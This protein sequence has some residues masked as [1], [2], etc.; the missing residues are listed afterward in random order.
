MPA[1]RLIFQTSQQNQ[2][3]ILKTLWIFA[4]YVDSMENINLKGI[5][6]LPSLGENNKKQMQDSKL[7]HEE[8]ISVF[9]MQNTCRWEQLMILRPR[10]YL[11]LI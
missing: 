2:E 4:K 9:L 6:V 5:M 8:L 1:F 11:A 7:L 3:L 10:L